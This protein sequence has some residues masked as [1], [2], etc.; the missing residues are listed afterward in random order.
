MDSTRPSGGGTQ[1]WTFVYKE[2]EGPGLRSEA[3]RVG[4]CTQGWERAGRGGG[5]GQARLMHGI[6]IVVFIEKLVCVCCVQF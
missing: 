3:L 4:P 5:E 1:S 6:V 2:G